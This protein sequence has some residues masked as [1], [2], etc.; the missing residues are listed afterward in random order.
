M[1]RKDADINRLMKIHV[2]F[3]FTNQMIMTIAIFHLFP[4]ILCIRIVDYND[5]FFWSWLVD[6]FIVT[7]HK[8]SEWISTN[9][10]SFCALN[11]MYHKKIFII[12]SYYVMNHR[13]CHCRVSIIIAK[14]VQFLWT[15]TTY[16]KFL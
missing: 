4:I 13:K 12:C 3:P 9:L 10:V 15:F 2:Y 7:D 8:I 5:F 11:E 6:C 14:Q 16:V 1:Q